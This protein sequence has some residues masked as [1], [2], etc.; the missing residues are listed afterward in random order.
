MWRSLVVPLLL[1]TAV[2]AAGQ[3]I[4]TDPRGLWGAL[5]EAA[6][7]LLFLW[8]EKARTTTLAVGHVLALRRTLAGVANNP[9]ADGAF[10]WLPRKLLL[11]ASG[12][13]EVNH[14]LAFLQR[15]LDEPAAGA[16]G[17]AQ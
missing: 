10:V 6:R 7:R 5:P 14:V 8:P 4:Y 17:A 12:A 16:G 11:I 2:P 3:E 1:L 15:D 9:L 13:G